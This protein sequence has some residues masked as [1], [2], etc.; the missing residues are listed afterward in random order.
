MD[1]DSDRDRQCSGWSLEEGDS[2]FVGCTVPT[3]LVEAQ[4]RQP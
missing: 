2:P 3:R 1:P 4:Q